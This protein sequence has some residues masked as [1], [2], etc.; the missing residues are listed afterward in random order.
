MIV[1]VEGIPDSSL[2]R[3]EKKEE[4]R[5]ILIR[6]HLAFTLYVHKEVTL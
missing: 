2:C 4:R 1:V 5:N 3:R 6:A